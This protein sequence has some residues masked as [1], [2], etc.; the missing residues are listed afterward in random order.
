MS[1]GTGILSIIR[2]R[3]PYLSIFGRIAIGN[4]LIIVLGAIGGTLITR[5]LAD[6]SAHVGLIILSVT[7]GTLI[8]V[9]TNCWI[10]Y[11]ALRPLHELREL[12]ARV[13]AGQMSI[14][15]RFLK[16][17]DPDI[18]QLAVALDSLVNQ[19]EERNLQ[20]RALSERAINAQEDERKSIAQ[21]LHDD[22]GQALSTLII[23]LERLENHLPT[24]ESEIKSKLM[25][26]RQLATT[27][28]EE[29]RKIVYGL[30][31][32]ILD[33]LGLI[34]AI[35]WY[36]RSQLETSGVQVKLIAPEETLRLSSHLSTI[37]FRITQE[38]IN[39]I[40]R[41]AEAK[42]AQIKLSQSNGNI[43]LYVHDD[44]QGFDVAQIEE[45]AP[46]FQKLG[47][48]GIRERAELIGGQVTIDSEPGCGTQ[49][50]VSVPINAS[51]EKQDE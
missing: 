31:P 26:A 8:L 36:A 11:S 45:Q 4:S 39:N 49:L 12:V 25:S 46:R 24:N 13:Q 10:I 21:S 48:L 40:V 19:L 20:L 47:L 44:G 32:T 34:P 51:Q 3:F 30:R 35:R 15:T 43:H 7:L 18:S 9:L 37:L 33:D 1:L 14:D 2:K 27:T 5:H 17:P 29:L 41:H 50:Y 16:E 6:R 28:L 23:N 38:A 22:T 42:T